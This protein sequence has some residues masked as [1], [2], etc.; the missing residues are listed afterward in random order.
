MYKYTSDK[1]LLEDLKKIIG[2]RIPEDADLDEDFMSDFGMDSLDF[3]EVAVG[4]EKFF[5]IRVD[6]QEMRNNSTLR[7]LSNYIK[8]V[9]KNENR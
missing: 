5:G 8:Q 2:D 1:V 3:V 6:Y 4:V 7:K 9:L